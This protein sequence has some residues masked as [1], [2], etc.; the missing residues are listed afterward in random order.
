MIGVQAVNNNLLINKI[1]KCIEEKQAFVDI[2]IQNINWKLKVLY[3]DFFFPLS[4]LS[5]LIVLQK[6]Y[7]FFSVIEVKNLEGKVIGFQ[8]VDHQNRIYQFA[9][10]MKKERN[11]DISIIE[12]YMISE[13]NIETTIEVKKKENQQENIFFFIKGEEFTSYYSSEKLTDIISKK[14]DQF[15]KM[16]NED[17]K[18]Y[19]IHRK[20][21]V[22]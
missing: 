4:S 8:I 14:I 12:N 6:D 1:D 10:Y 5:E 20:G 7:A 19:Q 17:V 11:N 18:V 16:E 22:I 21:R 15:F 3:Y 13:E 9:S 2:E